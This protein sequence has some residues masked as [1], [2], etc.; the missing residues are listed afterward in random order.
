MIIV[1]CV[2]YVPAEVMQVEK[3]SPAEEAGLEEGDIIKKFDGYQVDIGNDIYTYTTLYE[4]Q[5]NRLRLNLRE[6]GRNT[7]LPIHQMF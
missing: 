7:H 1:G 3:G 4:L 5:Q 6:M 2:G